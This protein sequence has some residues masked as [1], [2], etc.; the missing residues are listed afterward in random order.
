M[1][2]KCMARKTRL[3]GNGWSV[4]LLTARLRAGGFLKSEPRQVS[5]LASHESRA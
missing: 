1:S 4:G 3:G 5:I 2:E